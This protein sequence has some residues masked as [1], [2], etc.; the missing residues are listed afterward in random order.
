MLYLFSHSMSKTNRWMVT[1]NNK[2]SLRDQLTISQTLIVLSN[3]P[4]TIL[5]PSGEIAT[6]VIS[7]LWAF[8]FL[9]SS[10][11]LPARQASKRQ[12][13]PRRGDFEL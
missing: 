6:D 2:W 10:S 11:S 7:R 4:D 12:C 9:L 13:W 8:I 1:L 5:V 3:D